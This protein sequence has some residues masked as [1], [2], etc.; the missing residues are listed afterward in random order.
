MIERLGSFSLR[1][2]LNVSSISI[3]NFQIAS[4]YKDFY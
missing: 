3:E 1:F 2:R 4:Y